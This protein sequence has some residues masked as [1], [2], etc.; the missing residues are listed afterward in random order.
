ML[1]NRI[2]GFFLVFDEEFA[3]ESFDDGEETGKLPAT[4]GFFNRFKES[5]G[6]VAESKSA[7]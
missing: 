3:K 7:W 6:A 5:S 4:L 1:A 2:L